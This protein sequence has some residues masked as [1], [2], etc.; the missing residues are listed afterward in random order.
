MIFALYM[1]LTFFI[2]AALALIPRKLHLFEHIFNAMAFIYFYTYF[3]SILT[4]LKLVAV[5]EPIDQ[6][7]LSIWIRFVIYPAVLLIY[8]NLFLAL[9]SIAAK[10]GSLVIAAGLLALFQNVSARAG[11]LEQSDLVTAWSF[12]SWAG[13]LLLLI[14]PMLWFRRLAAKEVTLP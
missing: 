4:N 6:A 8:W 7:L 14:G 11:A 12:V 3:Y 2:C 13:L 9:R 5:P 10:A 1:I